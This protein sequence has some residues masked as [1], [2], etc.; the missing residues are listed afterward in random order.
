MPGID[1]SFRRL[2]LNDG[3]VLDKSECGYSDKKLWCYLKDLTFAEAFQVFSDP[4]KI[5]TIKFEYGIQTLYTR[6][7]YT[8]FSDIDVIMK[9]EWSIDICLTGD[10]ITITQEEVSS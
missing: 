8:G 9:H 1:D 10:N 3:T 2:V 5:K 6:I 7:T 4:E